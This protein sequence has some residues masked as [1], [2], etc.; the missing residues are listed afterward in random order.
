MSI[1][2]IKMSK[3][4]NDEIAIAN[5]IATNSNVSLNTDPLFYQIILKAVRK[6]IKDGFPIN[7]YRLGEVPVSNMDHMVAYFHN[8]AELNTRSMHEIIFICQ[9]NSD[10]AIPY[11][12]CN[13]GDGDY[14]EERENCFSAVF[15]TEK[16]QQGKQNPVNKFLR[17][18]VIS[19]LHSWSRQELGMIRDYDYHCCVL[20]GDIPLQALELIHDVSHEQIFGVLGNH[21]EPDQLKRCGIPDLNGKVITVNGV[22]IAGL[23]GSHRYKDGNHVML[24][25]K[26][27]I[28]AAKQLPPAD[29]LISHDTVYHIMGRK[30]NAHCGLK[31]ISQYIS[32]HKTKLNLCGH[33]HENSSKSYKGCEI[34][35]VYGCS[36][37]DFCSRMYKCERVSREVRQIF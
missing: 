29:I 17:I 11:A 4:N 35:C 15:Q 14:I 19:D 2:K 28:S 16:P 37:I 31:G 10:K 1:H 22:T 21:D 23:S 25:Q 27:S 8:I 7:K 13:D 32:N 12:L 30:D 24:S 9:N 18:M 5:V 6:S 34:R 3:W 33:Y 20:L 36:L 26:E